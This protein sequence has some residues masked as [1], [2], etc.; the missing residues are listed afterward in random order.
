MTYSV[1]DIQKI[2]NF[3]SWNNRK[4]IDKL[5]EIDATMYM[6]LGKDS[7]KSERDDTKKKSRKIYRAIKTLDNYWGGL[8]LREQ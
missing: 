1:E 3:S 6:G 4:K 7:T 5:L 2:L 8:M